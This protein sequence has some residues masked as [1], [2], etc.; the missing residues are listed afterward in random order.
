MTIHFDTKENLFKKNDENDELNFSF[1]FLVLRCV[2]VCVRAPC[3]IRF[4]ISTHTDTQTNGSAL[5]AI[6]KFTSCSNQKCACQK[7]KSK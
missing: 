6:P 4:V 3:A 1:F 7:F 2:F 5:N